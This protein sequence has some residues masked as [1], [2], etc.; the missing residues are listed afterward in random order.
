MP[1][2]QTTRV[3]TKAT[4]TANT[5]RKN[6]SPIAKKGKPATA[7]EQARQ[8]LAD[9][10]CILADKQTTP[11]TLY[12][13]FQSILD[14]FNTSLPEDVLLTLQ[15]F[16]ALLQESASSEQITKKAID[17]VAQ[18]IQD[19]VEAT[20]EK[21]LNKMSTMAESLVANQEDLQ[22]STTAL[23]GTTDTL[24]KLVQDI[25]NSVKETTVASSQLSNTVCSYKDALLTTS[26]TNGPAT[27]PASNN[28]CEDP[29]LVRD[30]DCK[31]RQLLLELDKEF[32]EGKSVA[33]LKD[34][35]DAALSCI[36]PP[37][38][39]GARVQEINKLRNGGIVIQLLTKEAT[40]WLCEPTNETAFINKMGTSTHIKDRNFPIL[41]PRVPLS[42]DPN[43]QEHLREVETVNNLPPKTLSKARRIK[44]EYRRH[45]N[46]KFAYA[47]LLLSS[48][49]EANRLIR[50]GMYVCSTRTFPKRLKYKPRQCMKCRKWGHYASECRASINT[51]GTCRGDHTTRDCD[52]PGKRHCVACH[53]SEH[54]SWDRSCPEFQRKSAHFDELH[55]ENALTYFPTDENWTLNARPDR[56]PL[57]NR[58]PEKY[59]VGLPPIQQKAK[60]RTGNVPNCKQKKHR[61]GKETGTQDTI[62]R[63]MES[64]PPGKQARSASKERGTEEQNNKDEELEAESYSQSAPWQK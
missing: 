53:S 5:E 46:Q 24:Q 41:V 56:I 49:M 26:N 18:R 6:L 34:K 35:I 55:P 19:K 20:L 60:T 36:T 28:T 42:F 61:T 22:G 30:L 38:P 16:A 23:L 62:D 7:G 15:A 44:P 59:S 11:D 48:A 64:Q 50:D 1:T 58:F 10:I 8:V 63:Y 9:K 47:T 2:S 29:R 37:P 32:T 43:N 17:A 27:S 4:A 39:E 33:E 52:E 21:S 51:C 45:P 54:T 12:K 40:A 57:E 31:Q 14:K 25:G 3:S 13:I